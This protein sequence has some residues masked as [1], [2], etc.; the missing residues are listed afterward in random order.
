MPRKKKTRQINFRPGV[1]YFKPRGVLLRDLEET[2]LTLDELEALRLVDFAGEE[3]T[4]AAKKMKVSQSTLQRI[5]AQAR[6]K[7]AGALVEGQAIELKGGE[8]AMA[9][10]RG[11]GPSA[12][13]GWRGTGRGLGLGRGAGR[14]L[15]RGAGRGRGRQGGQ[16]AAGPGG[17]C[18]CTNPECKNEV[19]HQAGQ[20]CYQAKCP[21]C[22]SPMVRKD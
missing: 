15:G 10:G 1:T 20:P 17:V 14:G 13:S 12:G 22:G 9:I 18:V 16:F 6:R 3:Q 5:L 21:K 8:V 19:A 4:A 11:L 7:V 2:Q